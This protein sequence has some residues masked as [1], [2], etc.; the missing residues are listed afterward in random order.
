MI[1]DNEPSHSELLARFMQLSKQKQLHFLQKALEDSAWRR[2]AA[3]VA[4]DTAEKS[5]DSLKP[6]GG[7]IAGTERKHE[8]TAMTVA[9]RNDVKEAF[10]VGDA[11][12][13][14]M[15]QVIEQVTDAKATDVSHNGLLE[16]LKSLFSEYGGYFLDEG[17]VDVV[18]TMCERITELETE[19]ALAEI[20]ADAIR[21]DIEE[22]RQRA[23][24]SEVRE[25]RVIKSFIEEDLLDPDENNS[26]F[27]EDKQRPDRVMQQYL[28]R[29]EA[30][31]T[32]VKK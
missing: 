29:I 3:G 19:I 1:L 13:A 20:E 11:A 4:D 10:G 27:L 8:D 17:E 15:V 25:R 18:E 22:T 28:D 31:A 26:I 9:I 12:L 16:Q 5:R 2:P 7:T 24:V 21:R 23:R 30:D 6:D 32:Y 14:R